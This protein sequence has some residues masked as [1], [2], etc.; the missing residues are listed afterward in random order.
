MPKIVDKEAMRLRILDAAMACF[1]RQGYHDTKMT[2]VA[3][4]ADLAKGT[5]YL[6]FKGK[7]ALT[8]ALITRYFDDLKAEIGSY[9]LPPNL[10][11]FILGLR[12]S[13]DPQRLD[14]TR[15]M[16]DVFGPGF[17]R[18]EARQVLADFFDWLGQLYSEILRKLAAQGELRQDADPETMGRAIASLLDGLVMHLSM[19]DQTA[20]AFVS[21]SVAALSIIERGLRP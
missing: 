10:E 13:L 14:A 19:F 21:Q 16:L 18:P 2:D 3:R 1:L 15:M 12:N 4:A 6:Y 11:I 9:P 5:L 7:D 20:D 17:D 8:L